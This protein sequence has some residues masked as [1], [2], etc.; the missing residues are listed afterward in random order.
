MEPPELDAQVRTAFIDVPHAEFVAVCLSDDRRARGV[1]QVDDGRVEW[2]LEVFKPHVL[3]LTS[4]A[5]ERGEARRGEAFLDLPRSIAEEHVVGMFLVHMLS[6]TATVMPFNGPSETA[7]AS[8][9]ATQTSA[10]TPSF[11]FSTAWR[12]EA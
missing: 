6:L 4:R 9:G 11:F 1:Q 3:K 2:R 10:F 8:S 5:L 12:H 7:P